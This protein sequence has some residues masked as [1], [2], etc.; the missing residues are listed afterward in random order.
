M[1]A[2]RLLPSAALA[3]LAVLTAACGADERATVE[4]ESDSESETGS[5][6]DLGVD[7]AT[8]SPTVDHPYVAFATVTRALYEGE[9]VD[10]DTGEAV[11]IRVESAT[12]SDTTTVAG[13]EATIVDVD[14]YEDGELVERTE[15]YYAQDDSGVVYYLG[16]RVDDIEDGEVVAHHGEWLTGQDGARAGVFMPAEPS[17][18]DEFEQERAPGVAE[19][20]S[21]VVAVDVR[22]TVP[23]GTFEGCI[24]TEDV[25]PI[26]DATEH[27][28]YCPDVGLVREAFP[29][30][31]SLDL[32][33]FE[34]AD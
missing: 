23:A 33:E 31:G 22:V 7:P 3:A 5:P 11:E 15:D 29:A 27:K 8:L 25:D 24:E 16:E 12:R 20:R 14:E 30:G 17:V 19:D 13:I 2:P 34:T 10:E 28:F 26:G 4:T 9:E 32:I 1:R 18:G 21:R 6:S